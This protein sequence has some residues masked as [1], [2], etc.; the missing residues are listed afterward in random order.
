MHSPHKI[1]RDCQANEDDTAAKQSSLYDI[2][3]IDLLRKHLKSNIN[4]EKK[5]WQHSD[6]KQAMTA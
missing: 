1:A 2:F 3:L 6:W 5:E 4:Q